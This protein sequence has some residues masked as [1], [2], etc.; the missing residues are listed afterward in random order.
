MRNQE[1]GFRT[2]KALCIR[3]TNRNLGF[4]LSQKY[5]GMLNKSWWITR[6][7]A[8]LQQST[9]GWDSNVKANCAVGSVCDLEKLRKAFK[10]LESF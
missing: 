6:L 8:V 10:A 1:K 5:E 7:E 2:D 9:G 3:Q 4:N